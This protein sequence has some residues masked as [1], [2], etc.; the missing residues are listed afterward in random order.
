MCGDQ[1]VREM[2]KVYD[3]IP[4]LLRSDFWLS[5]L[6]QQSGA[7]IEQGMYCKSERPLHEAVW[8]KIGSPKKTHRTCNQLKL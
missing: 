2:V 3:G 8:H 5:P 7:L 6:R 1:Q 4:T